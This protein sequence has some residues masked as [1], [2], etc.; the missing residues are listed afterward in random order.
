MRPQ[1]VELLPRRERAVA[2]VVIVGGGQSGL[3][4]AYAAGRAGLR[5]LVL[6]AGAEPVG[7][8]PH[9]YDSL[10]LFSPARFSAL[11]GRPFPGDGER[12]PTR[13][14]VVAY[15]RAY[16]ANLD[17]DIRCQQRVDTLDRGEDARFDRADRD[18]PGSRGR[19]GDRRDR[20]LPA[21]ASPG[22]SGLGALHRHGP[23]RI[24]VPGAGRVR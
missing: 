10:A 15:L 23:A 17:A 16:A 19:D 6:E 8:W 7:S 1:Q 13:D 9:Y 20:R 5:P 22:A 24:A 3:A 2:D 12:Y 21:P 14:E 4:A 11:P 18:G